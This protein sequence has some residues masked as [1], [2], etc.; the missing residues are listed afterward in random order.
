M[1]WIRILKRRQLVSIK[2][3]QYE[4]VLKCLMKLTEN[5]YFVANALVMVLVIIERWTG[6]KLLYMAMAYFTGDTKL[7][8]WRWDLEFIQRAGH[9]RT[10][11]HT[12]NKICLI[13]L[14]WFPPFLISMCGSI[15]QIHLMKSISYN[16]QLGS[17]QLFSV[18]CQANELCSESLVAWDLGI[19]S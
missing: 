7:H 11:I 4:D 5:K 1:N 19:L 9:C 17:P 16:E 13:N 3:M 2:W 15:N 12:F 6:N 14:T 10:P 18:Q 8:V